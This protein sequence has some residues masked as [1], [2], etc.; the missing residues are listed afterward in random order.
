MRSLRQ[1]IK[2]RLDGYDKHSSKAA[3]EY[4]QTLLK[5]LQS[6]LQV[7][8][9]K[10]DGSTKTAEEKIADNAGLISRIKAVKP[11]GYNQMQQAFADAIA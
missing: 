2:G 6:N 7:V 4:E 10:R 9:T 5:R 8:E 1:T 11:R 3:R